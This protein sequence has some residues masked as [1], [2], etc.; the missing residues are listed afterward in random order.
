MEKL[1]PAS[2]FCLAAA[3]FAVGGCTGA[4]VAYVRSGE[5]ERSERTAFFKLPAEWEQFDEEEF[6][7][8]RAG[9]I[10][11]EQLNVLRASQWVLVF[12]AAPEPSIDHLGPDADHPTG[13]AQVRA[14][15]PAEEE[16]SAESLRE[17]VFPLGQLAG[18]DG[19]ALIEDQNLSF[20]G[21]IEGS[22]VT[23]SFEIDGEPVTVDQVGAF[24]PRTNVIYLLVVSCNARCYE[25]ERTEI[26][27]LMKSWTV[28]GELR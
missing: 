2:I 17:E 5:V 7:A 26:D 18:E 19:F 16:Y 12:D 23:F 20:P 8:R 4:R 10:T 11:E 28:E 21:G 22:R 6:L 9:E 14:L 3:V 24:D 13:F 25:D 15:G 1:L 27:R